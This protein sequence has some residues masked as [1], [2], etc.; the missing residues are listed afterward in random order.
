[1]MMQP[2]DLWLLP[3]QTN[4]RPLD[5]PR[6]RTIHFQAPVRAP[7]MIILEVLSQEPPQMSHPLPKGGAVD[8]VPIA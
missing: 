7:V 8:I 5:R 6:H 2:T 4:I 3:D 1:M